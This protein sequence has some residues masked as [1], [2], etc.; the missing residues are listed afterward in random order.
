MK[1]YG[2]RV[3]L[4]NDADCI[5]LGE[6]KLGAG[7]G[8]E[9]VVGIIW[10]TGVGAGLVIHGN[11]Y[12]G[13]TGSSGEFGH[14]I[15]DPSGPRDRLGWRGT[16]EAYAG[17]PNLVSNYKAAGG[18]MKDANPAKIFLS[19]ERTA[20]KVFK[21]ALE[22]LAIGL[23][24][25]M[26]VLNPGVIVIGGGL[27]NLPVYRE[28]NKLTKKYTMDGLRPHVRVVRNKLGDSAGVYGAAA[29]V[30]R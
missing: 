4:A 3:R 9:N 30:F 17:G 25:L 12:K 24:G 29:L 20:K 26:H 16:V 2:C 1:K 22:K 10:G 28:L 6:A 13:S 7:K 21:Q 19:K 15:V 23:A 11:I 18:K 8:Y 27:S 14:N 5:A